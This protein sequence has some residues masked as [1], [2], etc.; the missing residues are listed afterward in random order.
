MKRFS[1]LSIAIT[2]VA[3]LV[4]GCSSV[5]PSVPLPGTIQQSANQQSVGT[6]KAASSQQATKRTA[7]AGSSGYSPGS[8]DITASNG[9]TGKISYGATR[10]G[11]VTT[12]ILAVQQGA[13]VAIQWYCV[14]YPTGVLAHLMPKVCGL[15]FS[16]HSQQAGCIG[17]NLVGTGGLLE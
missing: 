10:D 16:G 4:G 9:G 12:A 8:P 14:L 15:H 6:A 1:S 5:T 13:T 3:I 2:F 11:S 7:I 17:C